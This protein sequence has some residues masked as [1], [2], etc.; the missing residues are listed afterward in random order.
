MGDPSST[1]AGKCSHGSREA[2]AQSPA[3][4]GLDICE[5]AILDVSR[6]F[7]CAYTE[8]DVPHWER[9]LKMAVDHFQTEDGPA[10][11]I[12]LLNVVNAMR[13]TRRNMFRFNSPYCPKCR[14]KITASES[15]LMKSIHFARRS[16][17]SVGEMEALILCEGHSADRLMCAIDQLV[18]FLP[19]PAEG[20]AISERAS[21]H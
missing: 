12:S 2:S 11:A 18:S 6:H 13:S 3:D 7:F 16:Q 5:C 8:T 4:I 14:K 9:A 19:T 10:I 21:L 1:G 17:R 15:N 20:S